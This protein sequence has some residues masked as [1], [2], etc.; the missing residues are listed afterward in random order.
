[1]EAYYFAHLRVTSKITGTFLYNVMGYITPASKPVTHLLLNVLS[2]NLAAAR[3]SATQVT[4]SQTSAV[5]STEIPI[6]RKIVG[7][8]PWHQ[9]VARN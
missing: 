5:L 3:K 8:Q 6:I 4:H 1:M 2:V 7:L 9:K